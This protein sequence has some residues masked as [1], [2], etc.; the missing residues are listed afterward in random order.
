MLHD[1]YLLPREEADLIASFLNPMLRL[2]PEKRA[3]ASEL[4]HHA[5][6]EGVVVQGEID[7]I[8]RAED[9]DARRKEPAGRLDD[10][11]ASRSPLKGKGREIEGAD[12]LKP[13]EEPTTPETEDVPKLSVP[14]P[15]SSSGKENAH[16]KES[17][18]LNRGVPTL[19]T[20]PA[21]PH[22][23]GHSATE[24]KR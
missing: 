24:H 23:K 11:D 6:L 8:R 15:S 3:K 14:V 22:G 10:S 5:W 7:V 12:A 9:E 13:V 18:H 19:H 21:P 2:I 16:P 4:I 1:K 20:V 17:L